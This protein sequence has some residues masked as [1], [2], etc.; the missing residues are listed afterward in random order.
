ML[1]LSVAVRLLSAAV[2][3]Q[4]LAIPQAP[5]QSNSRVLILGGGV[6]GIMA[7][8]TFHDHGIKDFLIIE[9]REELGGRLRSASFAGKTVELGANW[10]QGTYSRKH[11]NRPMNPIFK[12]VEKH[13]VKTQPSDLHNF[14]KLSYQPCLL[15]L[16][17]APQQRMTKQARLITMTPFMPL[18]R[19]IRNLFFW[20][21]L[22]LNAFCT[23]IKY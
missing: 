7:A 22:L 8:R 19:I 13:G 23:P 17:Q 15:T 1:L 2:C 18:T 16:M 10:V 3:I 9:G 14:S 5:Y 6:A 12:L 11:P 21:V 20:P 4:G